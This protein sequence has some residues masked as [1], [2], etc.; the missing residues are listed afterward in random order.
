MD[1]DHHPHD[2]V[3]SEV[4]QIAGHFEKLLTTLV[5]ER[6]A[7]PGVLAAHIPAQRRGARRQQGPEQAQ[8]ADLRR[9]RRRRQMRA[10][11]QRQHRDRRAEHQGACDRPGP[12]VHPAHRRHQKSEQR[13]RLHSPPPARGVDNRPLEA[14]RHHQGGS[15]G[16]PRPAGCRRQRQAGRRRHCRTGRHQP[17]GDDRDTRRGRGRPRGGGQ[18]QEQKPTEDT[19]DGQVSIAHEHRPYETRWFARMAPRDRDQS[20][21]VHHGR[22]PDRLRRALLAQCTSPPTVP[23]WCE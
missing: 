4:V 14:G 20:R 3:R 22:V 5:R 13:A 18:A 6:P 15:G 8:H 17:H 9:C 2:I 16:K 7:P 1:K 23:R 19:Q 11:P 10:D 21:S 12:P